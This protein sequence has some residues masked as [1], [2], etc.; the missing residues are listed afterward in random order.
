MSLKGLWSSDE[1]IFNYDTDMDKGAAARAFAKE[2]WND[3]Y[4]KD[5]EKYA[6]LTYP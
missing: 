5:L 2:E 3:E 4:F 6:Q 1:S